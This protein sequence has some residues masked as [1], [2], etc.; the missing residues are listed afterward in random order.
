LRE[1]KEDI[2]LLARSFLD[3]FRK[4]MDKSLEGFAPDA[5]RH[6]ENYDWPGNVRELENTVERAVAL[7][8]GNQ[9]T[10]DALPEKIMRKPPDAAPSRNDF[11]EHGLDFEERVRQ[12]ERALL[13]AALGRTR[14]VG[15]RAAELLKMSY[16]SY[17]HYA[18]KHGL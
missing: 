14:G 8:P 17:K 6:L 5:L 12:T 3:R 16:R 9:I 18:K 10:A 2:P 4:S 11:P 7:E 15:T 13:E 1:R